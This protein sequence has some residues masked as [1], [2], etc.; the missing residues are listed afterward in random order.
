MRLPVAY[1][2]IYRVSQKSIAPF[3]LEF[4]PISHKWVGILIQNFTH[5]LG[6]F[7]CGSDYDVMRISGLLMYSLNMPSNL[8]FSI[9]IFLTWTVDILTKLN[10]TQL[11]STDHLRARA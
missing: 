6:V 7:S 2:Q 9:Y 10:S 3:P 5:L 11:N 8:Q 4:L 1:I